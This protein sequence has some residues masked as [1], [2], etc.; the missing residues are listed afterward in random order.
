MN[1]K[2]LA[3]NNDK[4]ISYLR[5]N[6]YCADYIDVSLEQAADALAALENDE[7]RSVMPKWKS[8]DN[9]LAAFCGCRSMLN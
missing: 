2:N 3:E 4:L 6:H 7:D 8:S 5:D 1:F 9:E